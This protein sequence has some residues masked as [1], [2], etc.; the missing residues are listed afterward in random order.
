[1]PG[2]GVVEY[3]SPIADSDARPHPVASWV[4]II[5]TSAMF[6]GVH[7]PWQMPAIFALSLCLGFAY[8]RTNNLWVSV[9]MHAT[10]NS[11]MTAYFFLS[12][13]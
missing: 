1:M 12:R 10:F 9:T 2:A 3:V 5:I 13:G 11:L 7:T 8:E 6:A 4:A